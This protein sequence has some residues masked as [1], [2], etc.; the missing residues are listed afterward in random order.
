[1]EVEYV[2][3]EVCDGKYLPKSLSTTVHL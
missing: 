1:M 2:L 3:S